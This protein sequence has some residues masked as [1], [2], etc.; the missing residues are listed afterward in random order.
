MKRICLTALVLVGC[1]AVWTGCAKPPV[2]DPGK[3][4]TPGTTEAM[5]TPGTTEAMAPFGTTEPAYLPR[6]EPPAGEVTTEPSVR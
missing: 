6:Y 1:F 4:A 5:A 3:T 2:E